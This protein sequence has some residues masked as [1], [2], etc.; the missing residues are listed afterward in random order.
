MLDLV[1]LL[2]FITI[3][4]VPGKS[5][6]K[7]II[8]ERTSFGEEL[9]FSVGL[10]FG[11]LS[12]VVFFLGSIDILYNWLIWGI[13]GIISIM[14]IGELKRSFVPAGKYIAHFNNVYRK[15]TFAQKIL[16]LL[17]M[18]YVFVYLISALTPYIGWDPQVYHLYTPKKYL[19]HHRMYPAWENAWAFSPMAMEMLYTVALSLNSAIFAKLI[20][21]STGILCVFIIISL[22]KKHL[23]ENGKIGILAA[24]LFYTQPVVGHLSAIAKVDL[25]LTFFFMLT[26][27]GFFNWYNE[28]RENG[29]KW[30]MISSIF[31]GL[32]ACTKLTGIILVPMFFAGILLRYCFEEDKSWGDSICKA[33]RYTAI[34]LLVVAPWYV[35]SFLWT[36]DPLYP[37]LSKL[38]SGSGVAP[39][40][41]HE[42]TLLQYITLPWDLTFNMDKFLYSNIQ[43]S[44]Y[45][46]AFLPMLFVIRKSDKTILG[47]LSVSVLYITFFF[48]TDITMRYILPALALLSIV[49]GFSIAVFI[50][51]VKK[52]LKI[53]ILTILIIP[54]S[55]SLIFTFR[56]NLYKLPVVFAIESHDSYLAGRLGDLYDV[57]RYVNQN[58]PED[59]K[60]FS[61][62]EVRGYYL[63]REFYTGNSRFMR[64][65]D[66][67]KTCSELVD[68]MKE[69]GFT[70][71][72]MNRN[73]HNTLL[74]MYEKNQIRI[75]PRDNMFYK[76]CMKQY[77][78][79]VYSKDNVYLY[80][81]KT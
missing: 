72:L 20:H 58:L 60:I 23:K 22:S 6:L 41:A 31:L 34:G 5:L 13:I 45:F 29:D 68:K 76:P 40:H 54:L 4:Y 55:L 67:I 65:F 75:N 62:W 21:F 71:I 17:L 38:L 27:F 49:Y 16:S 25:G 64:N 56:D 47:L 10:G 24:L 63:E 18:G 2:L 35:R 57:Y 74:K 28:S 9:L 59:V 15:S 80:R 66:G 48:F 77:L 37:Y 19:M 52:Y 12:Y 11:L 43:A 61:P 44:P 78:R 70:H 39:V 50:G 46:L 79:D 8:S 73:Y 81:I 69:M 32:T 33:V 1:Y 7:T 3:C 51:S 42:A 36:G 26:V 53:I 14:T 30:L